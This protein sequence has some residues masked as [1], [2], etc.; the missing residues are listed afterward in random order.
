MRKLSDAN[1]HLNSALRL[2]PHH[3]MFQDQIVYI[4][5][6]ITMKSGATVTEEG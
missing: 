2:G 3:I 5:C 6:L 1:V 4:N